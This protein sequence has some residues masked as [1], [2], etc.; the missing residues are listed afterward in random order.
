MDNNIKVTEQE[1]HDDERIDAFLR[2]KMSDEDA[3]QFLNELESNQELKGKAIAMARM[4]KAMDKVGH[5]CEEETVKL[6]KSASEEE[7]MEVVKENLESS[8]PKVIPLWRRRSTILSIAAS[9]LLLFVIGGGYQFIDYRN[10]Q[11]LADTYALSL[12][13]PSNVRGEENETVTEELAELYQNVKD[14]EEI[15]ETITHLA[16][17]WEMSKQDTYNS[18]TN[19]SNEIGYELAIAYLRDNDKDNAKLVLLSLKQ[20]VEQESELGKKIDALLKEL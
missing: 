17:L 20:S 10:T 14:G 5:E 15:D 18:Y 16:E 8:G 2:G 12:D 1:I 7:F 13:S 9:L 6:L 4:I 11:L 19:Y 3:K